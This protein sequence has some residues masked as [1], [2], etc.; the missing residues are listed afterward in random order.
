MVYS[1]MEHM[2]ERLSESMTALLKELSSEERSYQMS[3]VVN[4]LEDNG[5]P[6]ANPDR[7]DPKKFSQELFLRGGL[8][9][10]V[11]LAVK[12]NFRPEVAENPEDMILRLLP[13]DGHLE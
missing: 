6:V 12:A 1:Q 10:F 3:A 9:T 2:R 8:S 5:F 11:D 4:L 7:T 13:S